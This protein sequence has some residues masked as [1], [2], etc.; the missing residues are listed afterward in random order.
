M[1]AVGDRAPEFELPAS[2]GKRVSL[3]QFAGQKNVVLFFYPKDNTP[4]CTVEACTF[5]DQYQD[6]TDAGAEVIG[7]SS[8]SVE[9]H[10][11]FAGKHRLP[12]ILLSDAGGGVRKSY[13]I[14][15]TLGILPG[16]V[17]FIVDKAGLVR[18]VFNSQL[19]V[20]QHVAESLEIL[21]TL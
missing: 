13:G 3:S 21:R 8:D 16:R 6:F 10:Q 5:R 2:D 15:S 17:T 12:M 14:P 11:Q 20:K 18:H 19:R 1:I 7:I 9:S 4:G